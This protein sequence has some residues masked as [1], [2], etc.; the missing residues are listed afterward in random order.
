[1]EVLTIYYDSD[2][3]HEKEFRKINNV[4]DKRELHFFVHSPRALMHSSIEVA[5]LTPTHRRVLFR[6]DIVISI[7]NTRQHST[8]TQ[9]N[10]QSYNNLLLIH[11]LSVH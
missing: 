11:K 4:D 6:P 10:I 1:M 5:P 8:H 9:Q 3:Q 2:I 7:T